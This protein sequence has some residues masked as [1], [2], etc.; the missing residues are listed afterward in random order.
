MENNLIDIH[1]HIDQLCVSLW[2]CCCHIVAPPYTFFVATTW[3][4]HG[5][6]DPHCVFGGHILSY[7]FHGSAVYWL[8]SML[9]VSLY[10]EHKYACLGNDTYILFDS[11]LQLLPGSP[12]PTPLHRYFCKVFWPSVSLLTSHF[13]GHMLHIKMSHLSV[14]SIYT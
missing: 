3:L 7:Y 6:M 5:G 8:T 1:C 13:R 11:C 2:P 12:T 9:W 10:S 14:T 4:S